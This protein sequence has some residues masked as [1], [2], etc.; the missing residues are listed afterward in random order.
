MTFKILCAF[1]LLVL[2]GLFSQAQVTDLQL[3]EAVERETGW[4]PVLIT[5]NKQLNTDSIVAEFN[6]KNVSVK[7]RPK[8]IKYACQQIADYSQ[9]KLFNW[10]DANS[11]AYRNAQNLFIINM[12]AVELKAEGV[13]SL[14]YH[15]G[16]RHISLNSSPYRLIAPVEPAQP[17]PRAANSSEPGLAVVGAPQMWALGYSGRG[18]LAYSVDTGIWP[19]H[20]AL[21][22]QWKGHRFPLSESWLP[23]DLEFPGDKPS[24]HGTHTTGTILGL[25]TAQADTIGLAFNAYFIA[26]DPVV[27]NSG[28]IRPLSDYV[29]T[30]QWCLDP[31]GNPETTSDV[32]DA[33]NNSWG[34]GPSEDSPFCDEDMTQ[35]L[36]VLEAAGIANVSSAGNEGPEPQTMS[37]PHNIN[38]NEVNAFT[39]GSVNGNSPSLPISDF[40]SRGPSQ[41]DATGSLLIKP[42]VSAPGQN[43][44]S[45]IG[46]DEYANFSGTSMACPHAVGA[47]LLLK[48]AYPFLPGRDLLEALYYSATDLGEPGEDNTFGMGVINVYNAFLYLQDMGHTPVPPFVSDFDL[49]ITE[50][51]SPVS[52]AICENSFTPSIRVKNF[53]GVPVNGFNIV[54]GILGET[55]IV[56]DYDVVLDPGEEALIEL[57]EY[58]TTTTGFVEMKFKV[59]PYDNA[60]EQDLF[61]NQIFARFSIKT[62]E[63]VSYSDDFDSTPID[64]ARW[65]IE[66][67]DNEITWEQFELPNE[68]QNQCM[69]VNLSDYSPR[70]SQPDELVGPQIE[71]PVEG[72]LFLAFDLAYQLRT[73]PPTIHDSLQVYIATACNDMEP[74][75]VYNKGGEALSTW[76]INTPEFVPQSPDQW[77]REVI[78]LSEFIGQDYVIP[79]FRSI[80]R[81][82]N[83]LYIDNIAVYQEN[84]PL[85][86]EDYNDFKA[87]I[88]PNP[89]SGDYRISWQTNEVVQSIVIL[90]SSGRLIHQQHVKANS[91]ELAMQTGNLPK[92]IYFVQLIGQ[93]TL[94]TLKMIVN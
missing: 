57:P 55:E 29:I 33:I 36:L 50:V 84:D 2:A 78:D 38:S 41:C 83:N 22:R 61:N 88:F 49:V 25:D 94:K 56:D 3:Q 17:A 44:R 52:N 37:V 71:T 23:W 12:I 81:R 15:D 80:N 90:D 19:D 62:E 1:P 31:D 93:S 8:L 27:S 76:E 59:S 30:Y 20:P 87:L 6:A 58:Q 53:G 73:G 91:A 47:I 63:T 70:A 18:R 24:S 7:E 69:R 32:P 86:L 65:H 28:A 4:I 89:T 13:L 45:A 85:S 35:M 26:T 68:D 64:R 10:M 75:L 51:V 40:S 54:Y 9:N 77:R 16:I 92:G 43:V 34:R 5:L 74:V 14:A 48:E 39:V 82:G 79:V 21:K 72:N 67:P 66:N 46:Q 11:I 60:E 42:E